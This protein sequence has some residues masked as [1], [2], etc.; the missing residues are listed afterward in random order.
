LLADAWLE[1]VDPQDNRNLS[2]V[3]DQQGFATVDFF[4]FALY[5]QQWVTDYTDLQVFLDL[6]L[7]QIELGDPYNF[8]TDDDIPPAGVINFYD[9]SAVAENWMQ[10]SWIPD[11]P[12]EP[13]N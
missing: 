8:F 2:G 10:T 7:E 13:G 12:V 9:F 1:P 11:E 6:W 5:G 4:D 3:D